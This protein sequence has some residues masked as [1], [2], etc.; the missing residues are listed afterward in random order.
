[1]T[2][3]KFIAKAVAKHGTLYD[4]SKILYKDSHTK[5]CIRCPIHGDFYQV[6]SAH[7]FGKGCFQ[8]VLRISFEKFKSIPEILAHEL[9][10]S[11]DEG[12]A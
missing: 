10:V 9:E 11:N 3:Q 7:L 6:A 5:V 12:Q 1:M 8:C 4:Y 2:A